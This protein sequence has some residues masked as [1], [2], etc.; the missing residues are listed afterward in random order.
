MALTTLHNDVNVMWCGRTQQCSLDWPSTQRCRCT[1][2]S[3]TRARHCRRRLSTAMWIVALTCRRTSPASLET[4]KRQIEMNSNRSRVK[5][6]PNNT[7]TVERAHCARQAD[8]SSKYRPI[9][10][11]NVLQTYN[12]LVTLSYR[13]SWLEPCLSCCA[14]LILHSCFCVRQ[15]SLTE[16]L[17]K[18]VFPSCA[19]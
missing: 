14:Y 15:R 3:C 8:S 1:C 13:P 10:S 19:L 18:R 12:P 11:N 4:D 2:V 5:D 9:D 16:M 17:C 6:S 7:T